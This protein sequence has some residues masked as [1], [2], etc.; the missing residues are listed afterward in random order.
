MNRA[1]RDAVLDSFN[2]PLPA[3]AAQPQ[4]QAPAPAAGGSSSSG[5]SLLDALR[6]QDERGTF[7]TQPASSATQRQTK[8]IPKGHVRAEKERIQ[9]DLDGAGVEIPRVM[10]ISM[11]AGSV[12]LNLTAASNVF[13][14]D[15]HWNTALEDQAIDR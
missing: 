3:P 12:G 11:G 8:P 2:R 5:S 1:R 6:V 7:N 10:L 4:A 14:M 13:L 15:P 9:R